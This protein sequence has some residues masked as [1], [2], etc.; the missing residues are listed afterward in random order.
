M[1]CPDVMSVFMGFHVF[2]MGMCS[3]AY[4][5][6]FACFN[7]RWTVT[8]GSKKKKGFLSTTMR[9]KMIPK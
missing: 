6:R 5:I 7:F 1:L 9:A 4:G 2:F 3:C 8:F